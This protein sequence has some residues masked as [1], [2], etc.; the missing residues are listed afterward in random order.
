M[1]YSSGYLLHQLVNFLNVFFDRGKAKKGKAAF[2]AAFG[3]VKDLRSFLGKKP[4]LAITATADCDMRKRLC[5]YLALKNP[6][7]VVISPNNDNIRY[8]V[9]AADKQLGCFNWLVELMKKEKLNTPHTIIFCHT[10]SDIVTIFSMLLMKLGKDAYIEGSLPHNKRC[11]V[12]VYYSATPESMK[13]RISNFFG[14]KEGHERVVIASTSLS[15]GVD[16]PNVRYVIHFGPGRSLT[17]HLQQAG[18]AGRDAKPA[19]NIIYYLGKHLTGCNASVRYVVKKDDCIRRLLLNN[20]V[21][22]NVSSVSPLHCCCSRCHKICACSDGNCTIPLNEFDKVCD[23]PAPNPT[24]RI[25]TSDDKDC[26]KEALM[27][28]KDTLGWQS[29]VI[30]FDSTGVITHGLSETVI[31]SLVSNC[32]NIFTIMD[33]ME[34][35]LASSPKVAVIVLEVFNEIFEDID[36]HYDHQ[37]IAQISSSMFNLG[38]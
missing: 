28:V 33:L 3:Q 21:D 10:V 37:E 23:T 17:D 29:D 36:N 2:R 35:G 26:L 24:G 7:Q 18:R 30:L 25:V 14:G 31:D 11:L 20:F 6:K 4:L 8:T 9:L 13:E 12:G 1:E 5:S 38:L 19:Y 34:A 22:G 15:M 16:Y 32:E 27:E